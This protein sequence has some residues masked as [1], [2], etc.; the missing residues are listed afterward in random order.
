M[1]PCHSLSWLSFPLICLIR[2]RRWLKKNGGKGT[3]GRTLK[4]CLE[5][6]LAQWIFMTVCQLTSHRVCLIRGRKRLSIESSVKLIGAMNNYLSNWT[7]RITNI[8]ENPCPY[9]SFERNIWKF[10]LL[11]GSLPAFEGLGKTAECGVQ[12]V[13]EVDSSQKLQWRCELKR[14]KRYFKWSRF[15]LWREQ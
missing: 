12:L 9:I 6:I 10:S 5:F 13:L 2:V 3:K 1:M 14:E 7:A 8:F 11:I 4:W 15:F